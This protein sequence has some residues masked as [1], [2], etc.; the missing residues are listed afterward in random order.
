MTV[1]MSI[2]KYINMIRRMIEGLWGAKAR[3]IAILGHSY[4]QFRFQGT[5][6]Q[7]EKGVLCFENNKL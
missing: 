1:I 7:G 4:R 3:N 2:Q 5:I 6:R